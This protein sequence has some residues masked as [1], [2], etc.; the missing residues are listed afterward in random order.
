VIL[1]KL[2]KKISLLKNELERT[3][4]GKE[5]INSSYSNGVQINNHSITVPEMF[6]NR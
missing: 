6:Q 4:N 2:E 5:T 3:F 1:A